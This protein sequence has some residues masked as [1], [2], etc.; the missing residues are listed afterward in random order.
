MTA[1]SAGEAGE[2]PLV[3]NA[4][5]RLMYSKMLEARMLEEAVAKRVAA[6]GKKKRTAA[7]RGQEA[8]RV[9]TTIDLTQDD[10]VSDVAPTAGMGLLLG[11]DPALL[12]R[13]L[14]RAKA[15]W[16][17]VLVEAGARQ[18]LPGTGDEEERLCL[19]VGAALALKT[20]GRRGIV[21][22]YARKGEMAPSAWRR[23]LEPA[24]KLDLPIV[25][26]VLARAGQR[27]KGAELTEVG[28]SARAAGVP[29]IPV[30]SCDA[31][32]L[33]RVTQ[34]SLGRTRSGDGPVL[35]ESVS[36]RVKGTRDSVDDPLDHLKESL[37]A[38]KICTDAWFEQLAKT[39]RG[40]LLRSS[41]ASRKA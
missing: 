32:A 5:L 2:N 37:L 16:N 28:K 3:P 39:T 7:I 34:E 27:K 22:A 18:M 13:E 20:Q 12:L 6:K 4:K 35:I 25:F 15:E 30:D 40:L 9:S 17:K 36:W 26:V 1:K 11:G 33:Y 14:T 41:A 31:V 21:V 23:V 8:V 19:A 38:R 10:L 24:Q 29:A